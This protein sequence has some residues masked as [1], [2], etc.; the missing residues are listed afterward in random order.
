MAKKF[1][2]ALLISSL[3]QCPLWA[4]EEEQ[5]PDEKNPWAAGFFSMLIPGAGQIYVEE[6][7]WPHVLVTVGFIALAGAYIVIKD[8]RDAS[9][10]IRE[11]NNIEQNLP[12][13]HLEALLVASQIAL[14]SYWIWNFGDAYRKA[15]EYNKKVINNLNPTQKSDIMNERLVSITLWRF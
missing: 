8:Q 11:V 9:L 15:E 12:D 10:K 3:I 6:E 2:I 13:A 14:P 7:F 1:F 4:A 5:R